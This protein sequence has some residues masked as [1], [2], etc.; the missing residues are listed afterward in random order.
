MKNVIKTVLFEHQKRS[1]FTAETLDK[2]IV[3]FTPTFHLFE[4][5]GKSGSYYFHGTNIIFMYIDGNRKL[6]VMQ[7]PNEFFKI[8]N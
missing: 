2:S 7:L 8:L 5:N 1:I 3:T 4:Y 6:N